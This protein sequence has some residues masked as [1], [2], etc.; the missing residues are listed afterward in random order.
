M[1]KHL[2][3]GRSARESADLLGVSTR[4]I[5]GHRRRLSS[6]LGRASVAEL[7]RYAIATS[8]IEAGAG[9]FAADPPVAAKCG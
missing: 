2:A 8:L 1:L 6:K 4:T 3:L 7:T 9:L 5:D